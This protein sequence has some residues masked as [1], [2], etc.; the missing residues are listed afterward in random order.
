MN[1]KDLYCSFE[2]IESQQ[3]A[4]RIKGKLLCH[5]PDIC[6]VMIW[7]SQ[8]PHKVANF[9]YMI[10]LWLLFKLTKLPASEICFFVV[11]NSENWHEIERG[12]ISI[13]ISSVPSFLLILYLLVLLMLLLPTRFILRRDPVRK[14]WL[15]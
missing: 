2:A 8:P 12:F 13:S 5:L 4:Q 14:L 1:E 15:Y 9:I 6:Y 7:L 11:S 3:K 10:N